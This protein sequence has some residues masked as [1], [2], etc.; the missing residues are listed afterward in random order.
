MS[1][2]ITF[3]STNQYHLK[4]SADWHCLVSD[5]H[6]PHEFAFSTSLFDEVVVTDWWFAYLFDGEL[7]QL[8]SVRVRVVDGQHRWAVDGIQS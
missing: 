1:L 5:L 6:F 4:S 8:P 7:L 3:R 2:D